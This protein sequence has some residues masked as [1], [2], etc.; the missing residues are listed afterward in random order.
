M[1]YATFMVL[2]LLAHS[3]WAQQRPASQPGPK[4]DDL[5]VT[6]QIIVDP[7]AKLPDEVVR[8]IPLPERKAV[9]P[10][11][12]PPTQPPP[13]D[14]DKPRRDRGREA[15]ELGRDIG[16]AAN[17]RSKEASEQREQARRAAAEERRRNDDKN[18]PPP[19]NPPSRPPRP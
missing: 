10:S 7:D 6:M 2:T 17:D 13:K 14:G 4:R 8:R 12:A 11:A 3:A 1:K 16:Q 19:Q 15:K 5:D 9:D 18:N